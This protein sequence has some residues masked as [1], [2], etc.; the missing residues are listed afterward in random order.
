M[1]ATTHLRFVVS[2]NILICVCFW[3]FEPK[4]LLFYCSFLLFYLL[5][6]HD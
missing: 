5:T 1:P 4:R 3:M 2:V 6:C